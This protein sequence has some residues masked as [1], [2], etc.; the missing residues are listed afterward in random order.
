MSSLKKVNVRYLIS[1]WVSCLCLF[2]VIFMFLVFWGYCCIML[3]VPVQLMAWED[4]P[5]NDLLCVQRY[6]KHLLTHSPCDIE[7][8]TV[9]AVW[10]RPYV[11]ISLSWLWT[12][13]KRL[14]LLHVFFTSCHANC[15][16]LIAP[17]TLPKFEWCHRFTGEVVRFFL[18]MSAYISR[19]L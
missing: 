16:S 15:F 4:C 10:F 12:E 2:C 13:S 3:S 6:V 9:C 11:S 14:K 17:K 19:K 5:Q 7:L 8:N 1:W 18:L